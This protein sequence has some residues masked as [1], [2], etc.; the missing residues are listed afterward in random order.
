MG[1]VGL[2]WQWAQ[3]FLL[4]WCFALGRA[5][6]VLMRLFRAGRMA[7]WGEDKAVMQAGLCLRMTAERHDAGEPDCM[8]TT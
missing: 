5:A 1:K 3:Q 6:G 2:K 8:R 7:R 4:R